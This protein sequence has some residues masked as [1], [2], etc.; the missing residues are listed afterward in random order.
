VDDLRLPIVR[1]YS[2]VPS[3]TLC[4]VGGSTGLIEIAVRDGHGAEAARLRR[5]SRVVLH[6]T[7]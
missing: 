5:G 4:A 7:R 3:G 2:E 1:T 6:T